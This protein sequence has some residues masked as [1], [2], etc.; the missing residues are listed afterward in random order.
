MRLILMMFAGWVL[1]AWR[2][3]R[4]PRARWLAL[5]L[6]TTAVLGVELLG[7]FLFPIELGD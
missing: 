2:G 3:P 7:L 5:G 4:S 1:L 6:V